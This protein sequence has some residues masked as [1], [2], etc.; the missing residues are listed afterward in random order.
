[1]SVN[2]VFKRAI[3]FNIFFTPPKGKKFSQTEGFLFSSCLIGKNADDE[4]H[5][6]I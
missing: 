2:T 3:Q 6:K 5:N 1:M 4:K